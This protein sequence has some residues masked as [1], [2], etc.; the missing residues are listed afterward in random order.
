VND[1]QPVTYGD[2]NSAAAAAVSK[3]WMEACGQSETQETWEQ[4]QHDAAR[5]ALSAA[6][7]YD[8]DQYESDQA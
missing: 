8:R 5:A 2:R 7:E 1:F 3:V 6:D 4:F